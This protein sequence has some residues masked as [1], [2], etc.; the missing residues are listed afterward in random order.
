MAAD[1]VGRDGE[2]ACTWPDP[3]LFFLPDLGVR[4]VALF[5]AA[6]KALYGVYGKQSNVMSRPELK[7]GCS[8]AVGPESYRRVRRASGLGLRQDR[9]RL[10]A[11]KSVRCIFCGRTD[12]LRSP[13]CRFTTGG[14][15]AGGR[16]VLG[17]R[18]TR[19]NAIREG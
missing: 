10:R 17:R 14:L 11:N 6:V 7:S 16:G 3:Y 15:A 9:D 12:E 4:F 1:S 2:R 19:G 8:A 13:L 18:R 5:C